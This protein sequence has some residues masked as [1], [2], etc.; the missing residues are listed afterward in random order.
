MY[1]FL[2]PGTAAAV[3]TYFLII[4]LACVIATMWFIRRAEARGLTKVSAID[5]TLVCLISGFLGA[6][7]L[8]VMYEDPAYYRE[9]PWRIFQIWN[10]GFV[11]Y[12]GVIGAFF[13]TSA[14]C[15]WRREPFWLWAD[16]AAAPISLGY[17]L[18]RIGCFLNGCCYGKYCDL[19]WAVHMQ[20]GLRHPTQLYATFWDLIVVG[21]IVKFEGRAKHVGQVFGAWLFLHALG[22]AI[23]E[24]FRDDPRGNM[25][26]GMSIGSILSLAIGALGATLALSKLEDKAK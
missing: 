3:S 20:G 16:L 12:G 13:G 10:G 8:H 6:R 5:I 18:G 15:N 22:R 24:M 2:F 4:S 21:L 26:F 14:F 9:S 1:P 11:F 25:I 7:L 17:A 23:M 19:P